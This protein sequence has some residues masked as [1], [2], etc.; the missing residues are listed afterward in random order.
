M[1]C[2]E[3]TGCWD[4][5]DCDQD[6]FCSREIASL[7]G[8]ESDV[9]GIVEAL[10]W[11]RLVEYC[12]CFG[13][14]PGDPGQAADIL[15]GDA[16]C[17]P[18]V[19]PTPDPIAQACCPFDGE[20]SCGYDAAPLFGGQYEGTCLPR[21]SEG[22]DDANCPTLEVDFPPFDDEVLRGCCMP[23]NVCGL[24]SSVIDLGCI[25]PEF[26]GVASTDGTVNRVEC[27]Y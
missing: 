21:N 24:R 25:A 4:I 18:F 13:P 2:I 11:C 10:Q 16:T 6:I 27:E 20:S 8:R 23:G 15:C 7:G 12:P 22:R 14:P 19:P 5:N 9:M 3:R 17:S 1:A 26:F